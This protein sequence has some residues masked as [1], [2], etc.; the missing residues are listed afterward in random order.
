MF[1]DKVLF[2]V[3]FFVIVKF[4]LEVQFLKKRD[5]FCYLKERKKELFLVFGE[6]KD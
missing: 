5:Y 3:F 6:V 2:F 1:F 4:F